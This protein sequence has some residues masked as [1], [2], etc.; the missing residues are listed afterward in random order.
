[1]VTNADNSW[2]DFPQGYVCARGCITQFEDN[3]SHVTSHSHPGHSRQH[4]KLER[5]NRRIDFGPKR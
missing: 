4:L 2:A 5:P 1:M 3:L